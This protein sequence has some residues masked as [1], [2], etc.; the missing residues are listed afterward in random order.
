MVSGR[1]A[2]LATGCAVPQCAESMS[3]ERGRSK[4]VAKEANSAEGIDGSIGSV[5]APWDMKTVG[6]RDIA[7]TSEKSI[8][9]NI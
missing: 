9:T 1:S 5:G 4:R 6:R 3:I 7:A 2:M 8:T